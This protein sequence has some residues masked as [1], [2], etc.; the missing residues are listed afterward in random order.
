[1]LLVAAVWL[2]S[3]R[4]SD[5]LV[6]VPPGGLLGAV[7]WYDGGLWLVTA[8]DAGF[9]DGRRWA[10]LSEPSGA[11]VAGMGA[12]ADAAAAATRAGKTG[13]AAGRPA[14][15]RWGV[16]LGSPAERVGVARVPLWLAASLASLPLWGRLLAP[17]RR[18]RLL[19]KARRRTLCR[20]CG[21]DLRGTLA[22]GL[23]R[24]PECGRR[25]RPH[26]A[27]TGAA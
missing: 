1:M 12:T 2:R 5:A 24:C 18:R 27:G 21:Y 22:A 25:I 11:A 19:V 10:V 20:E 8:P 6:V 9:A 13:N 4:A 3:T 26:H 17:L 7:G 15:D 23:R 14:V 16:L